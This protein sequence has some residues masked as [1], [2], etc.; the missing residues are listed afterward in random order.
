MILAVLICSSMYSTHFFAP[1]C[2][3]PESAVLVG[4]VPPGS[5]NLRATISL[6]V[7]Q[8]HSVSLFLAS[9][10]ECAADTR[11]VVVPIHSSEKR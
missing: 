5:L 8:C 9:G 10:G 7:C 6:T 3:N 4:A 2:A 11:R 1:L